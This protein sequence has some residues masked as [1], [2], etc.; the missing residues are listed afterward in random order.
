MKTR[1]KQR[2]K[3]NI[4]SEKSEHAVNKHKNVPS[5]SF[6]TSRPNRTRAFRTARNFPNETLGTFFMLVYSVFALFRTNV[7]FRSLFR[8]RFHSVR[9]DLGLLALGPPTFSDLYLMLI[10]S[11]G[12]PKSP[13]MSIFGHI[14][15]FIKIQRLNISS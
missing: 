10:T 3:T 6:G 5:V 7:R 8:T 4:R 9:L 14:R 12:V 13:K 1:S 11:Y 2:T 15:R